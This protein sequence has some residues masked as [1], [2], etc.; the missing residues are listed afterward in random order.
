MGKACESLSTH[1]GNVSY[2]AR[3]SSRTNGA[4]LGPFVKGSA[5]EGLIQ[6]APHQCNAATVSRT[7]GTTSGL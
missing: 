4:G 7:A 1:M 6:R 3:Q 2:E 5:G